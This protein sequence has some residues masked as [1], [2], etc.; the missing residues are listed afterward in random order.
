[1]ALV[2]GVRY[3]LLVLGTVWAD[4]RNRFRLI[5]RS[6]HVLLFVNLLFLMCK[7]FIPF[8]TTLLAGYIRE[9]EQ[10]TVA[11]YSGT[12]AVTAIFFTMLW[13]YI[14][15]NRRLMDRVT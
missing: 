8:S 9:P 13:L 1:M 15:D 11:I 5:A 12:L 7:A 3:Q 4:H 14:F 10:R 2:F 6:D